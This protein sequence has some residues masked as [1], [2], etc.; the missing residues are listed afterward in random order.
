MCKIVF[1]FSFIQVIYLY[2]FHFI[3]S[4]A[5]VSDLW[6]IPPS[7]VDQRTIDEW[8][9]KDSKW[10]DYIKDIVPEALSHTG[11]VSFDLHLQGV[12][13]ILRNWGANE[14]VCIA[15]LF[16]SIYGTEAYQ[17]FKLPLTFRTK[18]RE[19]I[20]KRAERIVWVF[21]MVDRQ[22]VDETLFVLENDADQ[23]SRKFVFKA[24]EELGAFDIPLI[25]E[26]EWLDYLELVIADWLEQVEGASTKENPSLQW[27]KGEGWSHRR[28]AFAKIPQILIRRRGPRL[29]C[30]Q[31]MY[32]EVFACEPIETRHL[33]QERTPAVTEAAKEARLAVSSAQMFLDDLI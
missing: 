20:G 5:L 3:T 22:S 6:K 24:R 33:I 14:A 9:I 8:K 30:A 19:L 15:G 32:D 31:K 13:A 23:A 17:G 4:S 29:Q 18:M 2:V 10:L 25:D 1:S 21:C 16:H 11:A 27:K 26:N 28:T 12:Q 7:H